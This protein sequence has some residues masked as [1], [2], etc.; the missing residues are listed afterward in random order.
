MFQAE[1]SSGQPMRVLAD[2]RTIVEAALGSSAPVQP[3]AKPALKAKAAA[4][5]AA[6]ASSGAPEF[7]VAGEYY[8]DATES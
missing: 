2:L 3:T 8:P 1:Y 4:A 6:P 7:E 5:S